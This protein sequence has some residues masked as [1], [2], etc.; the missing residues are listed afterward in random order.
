MNW[1]T[2]S[3]RSQSDKTGEVFV[4]YDAWKPIQRVNKN[5]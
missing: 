5:E 4:S 2:S 3:T 1:S